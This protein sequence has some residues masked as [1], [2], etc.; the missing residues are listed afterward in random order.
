M[1]CTRVL[2]AAKA[3]NG[4]IHDSMNQPHKIHDDSH[5]LHVQREAST[6]QMMFRV[7]KEQPFIYFL[8][9]TTFSATLDKCHN[10]I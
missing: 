5:F 9:L 8:Y 7:P 10:T 4:H 6:T 3:F 1:I 2:S